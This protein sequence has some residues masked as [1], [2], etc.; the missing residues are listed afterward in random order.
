MSDVTLRQAAATFSSSVTTIS[1]LD[2]MQSE[3]LTAHCTLHTATA[4]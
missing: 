2:A 4:Q 3:L 1:T